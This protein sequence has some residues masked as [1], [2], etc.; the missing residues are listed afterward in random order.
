MVQKK[1]IAFIDPTISD[2]STFLANV[3]SDVE[4]I[5][6]SPQCSAPAQIAD[7]VKSRGDLDAIHVVAHGRPGEV[8]L[9]SGPLSLEN[10]DQH[11]VALACLGKA[12][13]EEGE[14]LLWSCNS[15]AGERGA[16]FISMLAR[17]AGTQVAGASDLVGTSSRGG[18]WK[19][20]VRSDAAAQVRPP[21]SEEGIT[22][23]SGV[24]N[25]IV[26][27][28]NE[29]NFDYLFNPTTPGH[30]KLR[31]RVSSLTKESTSF[32][33][34]QGG[35][36]ERRLAQHQREHHPDRNAAIERRYRRRRHL[37]DH[38]RQHRR[39]QLPAGP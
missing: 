9:G 2:L 7:I 13:T 18:V 37:D 27:N 3:R 25:V 11:A 14:L 1:E 36:G 20:D 33:Q 26:L 31:L 24:M 28:L 30:N 6:L 38:R 10:I 22:R 21:L 35:D 15:A 32:D 4:A 12:L 23:Y 8:S 39:F 29:T 19:L 34:Q 5:V 17:A 16:E